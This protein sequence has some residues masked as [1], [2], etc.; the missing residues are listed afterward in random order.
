VSECVCVCMCVCVCV[1]HGPVSACEHWPCEWVARACLSM[2]CHAPGTIS[3]SWCSVWSGSVSGCGVLSVGRRARVSAGKGLP[4][5]S[6]MGA[7][8]RFGSASS[9]P[10]LSNPFTSTVGVAN[11]IAAAV[12]C[13]PN[14]VLCEPLRESVRE[15]VYAC[16]R[17][18]FVCVI[19]CMCVREREREKERDACTHKSHGA[20]DTPHPLSVERERACASVRLY[21]TRRRTTI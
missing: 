9:S 10:K 3:S 19:V 2:V 17:D 8:G 11:G 15:C 13:A 20:S 21:A 18:L 4:S 5:A 1:W 16:V 6:R 7:G 12:A 14:R